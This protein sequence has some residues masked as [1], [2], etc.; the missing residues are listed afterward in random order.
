MQWLIADSVYETIFSY[1]ADTVELGEMAARAGVPHVVLTHLIPRRRRL[2]T[3]GRS[4]RISAIRPDPRMSSSR[5]VSTP[6]VD[7]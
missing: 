7:D 3:S 6:P 5:K 1:H 2:A 4:Y